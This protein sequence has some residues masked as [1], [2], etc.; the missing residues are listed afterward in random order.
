MDRRMVNDHRC[1]WTSATPEES[2]VRCRLFKGFGTP[3]TSL[4]RRN[5]R[6]A[7]FHAGFLLG[8]GI[9]PVEPTHE[10]TA[11]SFRSMALPRKQSESYFY[12][13]S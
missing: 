6:Q 5:T 2:Q 7:L 9:T 4:T 8:R 1:P 13:I 12:F 10:A 11:H 3:V